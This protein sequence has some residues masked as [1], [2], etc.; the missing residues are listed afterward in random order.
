MNFSFRRVSF[1]LLAGLAFLFVSLTGCLQP[2]KGQPQVKD[3][4]ADLP[5]VT[6]TVESAVDKDN[7]EGAAVLLM[8]DNRVIY[9]KSFGKYNVDT[10]LPIASASK[11]LASS[12]IMTLVD[13]GKLSLDAPIST[14][15]PKLTD[16]AASITLRQLLSHTSGLPGQ[17]RCLNNNSIT[18][19]E[20]VDQIFEAGLRVNPGTDFSY[21]GVSYQ[22]AGRLA[23]IASGKSWDSLF[24]ERIK[25]PLN[26]TKTTYGTD[27]NPRIAGG[28]VSTLQDYTNLLQMHL[29]GGVFNNKRLLSTQ[30]VEEMQRDQTRGLPI[31]LSPHK[32]NRRYGF[33]EWRDIVDSKGRAIQLSC[34]GAFGFSPWIDRQRNLLGVF[35]VRSR[36]RTILPT[37]E[38]LQKNVRDMVDSKQSSIKFPSIS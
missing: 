10:V 23:E 38:K 25:R 3:A 2:L 14:Y 21:G 20:C 18:L 29:N 37:V 15:L 9:K 28:A 1:F 32:D 19:E 26:M 17:N 34:Q 33:G 11:L 5:I 7:L 27:K 31:R 30:A 36:W 6:R 12:T 8:R 4:A 22:V 35:L 16:N 24:E 13:E